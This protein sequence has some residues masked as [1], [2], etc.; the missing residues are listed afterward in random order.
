MI[1]KVFLHFKHTTVFKAIRQ[2]CLKTLDFKDFYSSVRI[3]LTGEDVHEPN[4]VTQ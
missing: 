3:L 2:N 1:S 4:F